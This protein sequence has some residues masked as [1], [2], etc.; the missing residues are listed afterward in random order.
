MIADGGS[1]HLVIE[2]RS[3]LR[4]PDELTRQIYA[5]ALDAGVE[6]EPEPPL[7]R[8]RPWLDQLLIYVDRAY[9][10][11]A[12]QMWEPASEEALRDRAAFDAV[13]RAQR[14]LRRYGQAQL[15]DVRDLAAC[16]MWSEAEVSGRRRG[17]AAG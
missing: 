12:A 13:E 4:T 10:R 6:F 15:E 2:L 9:V 7:S 8:L 11:R 17:R 3:V 5:K 16:L 14:E 1:R